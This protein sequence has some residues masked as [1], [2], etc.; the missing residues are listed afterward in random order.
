MHERW[1]EALLTPDQQLKGKA[2]ELMELQVQ[3]DNWQDGGF[4]LP[5]VEEEYPA[6]AITLPRRGEDFWAGRKLQHGFADS[7]EAPVNPGPSFERVSELP[8]WREE[9]PL[10]ETLEPVYDAASRYALEHMF[11]RKP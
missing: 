4:T 8:D 10:R 6:P 2:D 7:I 1:V 3:I 11:G 5:P 9:R